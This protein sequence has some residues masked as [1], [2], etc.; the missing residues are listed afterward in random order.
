MKITNG[1]LAALLTNLLTNPNSGE[2]D[3]MEGFEQFCTD[4]AE[5]VCNHCGG[6]V[7]MPAACQVS[8]TGDTDNFCTAYALDVE[9]NESSPEDG[10]I[11]N[12]S[13]AVTS[14]ARL[15]RLRRHGSACRFPSASWCHGCREGF[16]VHGGAGAAGGHR[17]PRSRRKR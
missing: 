8:E 5:V 9:P 10:G 6:E 7:R 13:S 17:L 12:R 4:L 11:W 3:S 1:A 2:I 16:G 15:L 14:A